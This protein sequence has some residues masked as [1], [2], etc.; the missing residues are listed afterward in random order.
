MAW[1]D[2]QDRVAGYRAADLARAVIGEPELRRERAVGG[3][4]AVADLGDRVEDPPMWGADPLQV[5]R[6]GE[7]AEFAA[8]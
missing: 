5:D 8:K 4:L 3:G 1:D 2:D 6:D 7:L